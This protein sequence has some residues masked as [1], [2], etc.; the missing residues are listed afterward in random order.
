MF[1]RRMS[2]VQGPAV[3]QRWWAVPI[4]LMV[5]VLALAVALPMLERPANGLSASPGMAPELPIGVES[6][7]APS[8]VA[9]GGPSSTAE[10]RLHDHS[11]IAQV[12]EE[13]RD[14][15]PTF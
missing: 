12:D 8:S 3:D 14:A 5:L 6:T 11:K 7:V 13:V 15:P 1:R 4:G 2:R 9:Q 10:P